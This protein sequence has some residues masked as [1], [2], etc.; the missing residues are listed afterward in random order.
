MKKRSIIAICICFVALCSCSNTSN[1][2][3]AVK[4]TAAKET[5]STQAITTESV[6]T[7]ESEATSKPETTTEPEV[8]SEP[9]T[10]TESE[11]TTKPEVEITLT[12]E[13]Q[14]YKEE[15]MN[16]SGM[17]DEDLIISKPD[18]M[19]IEDYMLFM[20][21]MKV[22]GV[23]GHFSKQNENSG[24]DVYFIPTKLF[25]EDNPGTENLFNVDVVYRLCKLE[26]IKDISERRYNELPSHTWSAYYKVDEYSSPWLES[27]KKELGFD[28]P[29]LSE[30]GEYYIIN[31]PEEF[32][33]RWVDYWLIID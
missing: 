3:E 13:E 20:R 33:T 1:E 32:W 28:N 24:S 5:V 18:D 15:F 23:K 11:T 29:C 25:Y 30:D 10:T 19:S 27:T 22:Y 4:T 9:E 6:E 26:E 31:W 16:N 8:T 12:P 21:Y 2:S 17:S 14:A 7:T